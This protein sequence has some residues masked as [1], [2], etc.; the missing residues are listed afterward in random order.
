MRSLPKRFVSCF[1]DREN[2]CQSPRSRVLAQLFDL[3]HVHHDRAGSWLRRE[4]ASGWASS[5]FVEKVIASQ[6]GS[7]FG[8]WSSS[9]WNVVIGP[10]LEPP[11]RQPAGAVARTRTWQTVGTLGTGATDGQLSSML[12]SAALLTGHSSAAGLAKVDCRALVMRNPNESSHGGYGGRG[13]IFWSATVDSL[14]TF[15]RFGQMA[16]TQTEL[17]KRH[18]PWTSG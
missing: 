5:P 15:G 6:A 12:V 11:W 16:T 8:P 2:L 9:Q 10:P 7:H 4:A 14:L 13:G 3:D 1:L 18:K 17:R